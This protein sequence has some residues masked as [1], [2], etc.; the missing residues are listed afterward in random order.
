M[1]VMERLQ[2]EIEYCHQRPY[3]ELGSTLHGAFAES[4]WEIDHLIQYQDCLENLLLTADQTGVCQ[5][6]ALREEDLD[7][8]F[9]KALAR[10]QEIHANCKILLRTHH[11]VR[12]E[13]F[14]LVLV[15]VTFVRSPSATE[16]VSR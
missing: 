13:V 4:Q 15:L 14:P 3:Q 2:F 12:P 5:V 11:Q 7:E 16:H 10:V 9:F 8:N 6:I 1:F